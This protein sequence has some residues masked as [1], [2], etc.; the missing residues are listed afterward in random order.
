[1]RVMGAVI[2]SWII[3][4]DE[5]VR[6]MNENERVYKSSLVCVSIDSNALRCNIFGAGSK[7]RLEDGFWVLEVIVDHID[8]T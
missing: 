6:K 4:Y 5:T 8:E 7:E 3:Q 1:M 2:V